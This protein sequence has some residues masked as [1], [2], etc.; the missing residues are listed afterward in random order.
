MTYLKKLSNEVEAIKLAENI[1]DKYGYIVGKQ[2]DYLVVDNGQQ[3]VMAS[4]D[5]ENMFVKK[6]E[7]EVVEKEVVRVV[8]KE[9]PIYIPCEPY[10]PPRPCPP[11][12]PWVTYQTGDFPKSE[13]DVTIKNTVM[14]I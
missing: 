11:K 4:N 7:R 1:Y 9:R 8:E 3:F 13:P 12:W 14:I 5:F 2:G 6:I 10:K